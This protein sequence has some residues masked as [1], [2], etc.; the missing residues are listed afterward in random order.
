VTHD[1]IVLG[2]GAAGLFSAAV[3]ARRGRTVVVIERNRQAGRKILIS[4]GGRCNFTNLHCRPEHFLS[5]NPHFARSALARYTPADFVRLIER[6]GIRYHEKTL[7]QLFCDGSAQE[8]LDLLLAE[9]RGAG[10]E[11]VTGCE[12][13][14]VNARYRVDS[15]QGIFEA[16]KLIVA[17]GGLSIAKLGS[18][19]L[20]YRLARQFGLRVVPPRPGLVPLLFDEIDGMRWNGLAGVATSVVARIDDASFRERLLVTHRGLSGPAMLQVS[21]YWTPGAAVDIDLLPDIDIER[22]LIERR[23]QG[24]RQTT[25]TAVAEHLPRRLAD[26]WFDVMARSSVIAMTGNDEVHALADGLHHWRVAP[27][28]TEGFEKAEVT[29]GGVDTRDLSSTTM[30]A[31]GV[32]GLY[33]IG[34]VVDVT[35]HLGGFNFQWAWASAHAAGEAV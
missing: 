20:G 23:A 15:S 31:R 27:S 9:C 10:V 8:V 4:G 25:R 34:E 18:T 35:G 1:V 32:P 11:V 2:G 5:D 13:Q 21:S 30:E 26:R 12:I 17:T 3:A 7:G 28:G 33:F 22:H 24:D 14:S 16:P 6:F 19:D 29:A